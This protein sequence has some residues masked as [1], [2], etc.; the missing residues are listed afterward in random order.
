MRF[1]RMNGRLI[2]WSRV[3]VK[4]GGRGKVER[5]K[6]FTTDEPIARIPPDEFT[7]M[8]QDGTIQR[9]DL[10][11]SLRSYGERLSDQIGEVYTPQQALAQLQQKLQD[12]ATSLSSDLNTSPASVGEVMS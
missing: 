1:A 6:L 4:I 2:S 10:P 9:L 8:V 12:H 5:V 3:Q 11:P 7:D